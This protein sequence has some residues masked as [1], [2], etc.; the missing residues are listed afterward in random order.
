LKSKRHCF[1]IVNFVFPQRKHQYFLDMKKL[2]LLLI[3]LTVASANVIAQDYPQLRD[4]VFYSN[5]GT[6]FTGQAKIEVNTPEG[7]QL[8]EI[9]ALDGLLHGSISYFNTQ[10]QLTETGHYAIGKKEGVWTQFSASGNKLGEAFYK[11]GKKDGIWTIWDEKGIKRY[12]MVYSMGKKVDTW[13]MWDENEQL[14]S[15]RI[16]QE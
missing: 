10:G 12:H 16:F 13:K 6:L 4:G 3:V 2:N 7:N 9:Q 15:E 14:V 8:Q 5:N 1:L 11:D